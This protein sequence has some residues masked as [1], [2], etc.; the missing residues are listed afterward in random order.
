M[1][2]LFRAGV[3]SVLFLSAA[4]CAQASKAPA[5]YRAFQQTV[6]DGLTHAQRC[7]DQGRFEEAEAYAQMVLVADSVKVFVDFETLPASRKADGRAAIE[8]AMKNWEVATGGEI[9]F[10]VVPRSQ[11]DVHITFRDHLTYVGSPAGG[12]AVWRRN[13]IAWNAN[14]FTPQLRATIQLAL[15]TGPRGQQM[16]LPQMTHAAMHELGHILGLRDNPRRGTVMGPLDLNNPVER[17]AREEVETLLEV[18]SE[19]WSVMR[20]AQTR[21]S[22]DVTLQAFLTQEG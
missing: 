19:A 3:V 7:V 4:L 15:S 20:M 6:I 17:P 16:T 13:V 8:R 12:I 1:R 5:S 18:R 21:S 11:A 10:D 9:R 14:R 22:S 2:F